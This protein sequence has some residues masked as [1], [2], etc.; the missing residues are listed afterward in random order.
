MP[1]ID[2]VEMLKQALLASDQSTVSELAARLDVSRRTVLRDLAYLREQG[3]AIEGEAGAGGGVRLRRDRGVTAVHLTFDE[4]VALWTA[5]S[6]TRQGTALPWG[7]AARRAL[8]KLLNSVP[9]SRARELRALLRRVVLGP[10]ASAAVA[11]GAGGPSSD[12]LPCIEES[13]RQRR[14]LA[15][16][17]VDRHGVA[18]RRTVEPHGLLIQPPVWYILTNDIERGAPRMFRMDRISRAT[19]LRHHSFAACAGVV[20]ALTEGL[21]G[22]RN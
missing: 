1:R 3:L 9:A 2:R 16:D 12:L 4:I 10:P 6:L 15:F 20:S 18:S 14:A 19:V 21:A 17:Y 13:L 11:A 7:S 8:D 22:V 5:A